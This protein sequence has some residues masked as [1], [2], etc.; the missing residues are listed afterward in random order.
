MAYESYTK[1]KLTEKFKAL[2]QVL[3]DFVLSEKLNTA[4]NEIVE[5]NDL[6]IDQAGILENEVVLVILGDTRAEDFPKSLE[7]RTNLKQEE[8]G[9]LIKE[10]NEKVFQEIRASLRKREEEKDVPEIKVVNR[11]VI[12]TPESED[13]LEKEQILKEIEETGEKAFLSE[14]VEDQKETEAPANIYE[15]KLTE[16]TH[17][18]KEEDKL[19]ITPE[20]TKPDPGEKR[21][22]PYREPLEEL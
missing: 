19:K 1:E 20:K 3:R 12:H 11:E 2:P 18:P 10:V 21:V 15:T 9:G 6:P 13:S 8:L 14:N 7:K 4:L 16:T 17:V 5:E 22:D